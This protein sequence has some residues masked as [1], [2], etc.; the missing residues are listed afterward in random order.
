MCRKILYLQGKHKVDEELSDMKQLDNSEFLKLTL[1][2]LN[3][4][5]FIVSNRGFNQ[6]INKKMANSVDSDTSRLIW[7]CTVWKGIC[8][9]L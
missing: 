9:G 3:L 5:T 6:K 4:D 1:P 7:I 2:S 8:T